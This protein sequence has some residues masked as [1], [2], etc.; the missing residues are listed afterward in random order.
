M[1]TMNLKFSDDQENELQ[2]FE[3]EDDEVMI[4]LVCDRPDFVGGV[5]ESTFNVN[6]NDAIKI[7]EHLKKEFKL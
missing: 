6:K 7:I 2:F 1:D 3:N 5:F 4:A